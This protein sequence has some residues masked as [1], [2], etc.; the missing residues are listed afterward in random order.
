M[1]RL[2]KRVFLALVFLMLVALPVS[3]QEYCYVANTCDTGNGEE[4]ILYL[5]NTGNAHASLQ[6]NP[7]YPWKL[8]CGGGSIPN[9]CNPSNTIVRLS[10][11][12]N[13]H[14]EGPDGSTY[15]NSVCYSGAQCEYV[16]GNDCSTASPGRDTEILSL[17]HATNAHSSM[18]SFEMGGTICCALENSPPGEETYPRV[19][20]FWRDI[21]WVEDLS[22][23][24]NT[25]QEKDTVLAYLH[26]PLSLFPSGIP[27]GDQFTLEVFYDG[28]EEDVVKRE[29]FTRDHA[30]FGQDNFVFFEWIAGMNELD[31]NVFQDNPHT[32]AMKL[33]L[34]NGEAR[35]ST[36]N[37]DPTGIPNTG[38]SDRAAQIQVPNTPLNAFPTADLYPS[39][40]QCFDEAEAQ[41]SLNFGGGSYD[42][43]DSRLSWV[44]Y[45]TP[46]RDAGQER[47]D[48]VLGGDQWS[49]ASA[50]VYELDYDYATSY[51]QQMITLDHHTGFGNR[52]KRAEDR[53]AIMRV[54]EGKNL[55]FANISYP[56]REGQEITS[57][58]FVTFHHSSYIYLCA[59]GQNACNGANACTTQSFIDYLISQGEYRI[60]W[61]IYM[62]DKEED[63]FDKRRPEWSYT[64]DTSVDTNYGDT[65]WKDVL[66]IDE[67]WYLVTLDISPI[68]AT[69]FVGGY[70]ERSFFYGGTPGEQCTVSGGVTGWRVV[71]DGELTFAAVSLEGGEGSSCTNSD[72]EEAACC[73]EGYTCNAERTCELNPADFCEQMNQEQCSGS[74]WKNS[75]P[76]QGSYESVAPGERCGPGDRG[77]NLNICEEYVDCY[78]RWDE[79]ASTC[80]L[81]TEDRQWGN[82]CSPDFPHFATC[83]WGGGGGFGGSCE[84]GEIIEYSWNGELTWTGNNAFSNDPT[85]GRGGGNTENCVLDTTVSPNVYRYDP[86][87]RLTTCTEGS[88][89]IPCPTKLQLSFFGLR[90]F[91]LGLI[92]AV[93]ISFMYSARRNKH[94]PRNSQ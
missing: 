30:Y 31:N 70:M 68:I 33:T 79:V 28:N 72:P 69:D 81:E 47:V 24:K 22:S 80:A 11:T 14:V 55:V 74:S 63:Y 64:I 19:E 3:A 40:E 37:H 92:L 10:D 5:S 71:D 67:K 6:A 90:E 59:P 44:A 9:T 94:L 21:S 49:D 17:S 15:A 48:H 20:F 34:P 52:Q 8:C 93:G 18:P 82:R 12:T 13:A 39:H 51:G 86:M 45:L 60:N 56:S 62:K 91:F 54:Q 83:N 65:I 26:F 78:C 87:N 4:A 76:A 35:L 42:R 1:Y 38:H 36:G 2:Q 84:A 46:F 43:D 41:I 77:A 7:S 57:G 32:Y 73:P 23:S 88:R 85:C 61:S 53:S 75:V 27:E 16:V 66:L 89:P 29:V 58:D 50:L 25:V